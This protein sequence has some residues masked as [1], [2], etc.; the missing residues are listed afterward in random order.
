MIGPGTERALAAR[1][2]IADLV[3]ERFVAEGLLEAFPPIDGATDG[4]SARARRSGRA[5]TRCA[6]GRSRG[7]GIRRRRVAAVPGVPGTP[8]P[9][10]L[11]RVQQGAVD[12]ITF[13]SSSTVENFCDAVGAIPDPQPLVASIGPVTSA[14]AKERGLRVDVEATEHTIDGLVAALL[15]RLA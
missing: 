10:A 13:T 2:V 5:G 1:G 12:A 15:D 4:A 11:E 6:A 8:D 3:P 7:E 9:P 14:T